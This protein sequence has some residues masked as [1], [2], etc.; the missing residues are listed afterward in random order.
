MEDGLLKGGS[1]FWKLDSGSYKNFGSVECSGK[2]VGATG[3][4]ETSDIFLI[5]TCW[6]AQNC[7]YNQC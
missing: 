1:A 3:S 6:K 7:F 4:S 5:S 2:V